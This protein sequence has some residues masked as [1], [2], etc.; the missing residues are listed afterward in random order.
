LTHCNEK[1]DLTRSLQ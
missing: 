1:S